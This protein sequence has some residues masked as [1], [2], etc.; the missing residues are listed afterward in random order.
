MTSPL[1]SPM[2]S[3]SATDL[4]KLKFPLYASPKL[5]GIRATVQG[6]VVLSRNLKPI[7]NRHVQELFGHERYNGLDGE[8]IVGSPTAPDCLSATS[9]GVM[10]AD[11]E[12]NVHFHAFDW[13]GVEGGFMTRIDSVWARLSQNTTFRPVPHELVRNTKE[14]LSFE[15]KV[16]DEGYEGVMLRSIDG[17]Y[18]EGR[19][20]EREGF[21]LKL[22]VF[23]YDKARIKAVE[24][25]SHNTNTQER[26]ALGHAKRS[27]AKAGMRPNGEVGTFIVDIQTGPFAGKEARV[28]RGKL[29]AAQAKALWARRAELIGCEIDFK[30]FLRG[31]KDLPRFPLYDKG[32]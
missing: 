11:G 7:R 5:D 4:D 14:L 6:G 26:D 12:P 19:S 30:Y 9:S 21:L 24:E 3:G 17:P 13:Y 2:L 15:A 16:L 1:F 18:K 29:T 28:G 23:E 22:K 20:T 8:L 10:S 32:L 25:G 27:T 31:C